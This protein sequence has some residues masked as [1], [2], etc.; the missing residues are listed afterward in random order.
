MKVDER[1]EAPP[2]SDVSR[3]GPGGPRRGA[4]LGRVAGFVALCVACVGVSVGYLV[5]AGGHDDRPALESQQETPGVVETDTVAVSAV[6]SAP[7]VV[8]RTLAAGEAGQLAATPLAEPGGPRALA[9]FDCLRIYVTAVNGLCLNDNGD[10]FTPYNIVFLGPDLAPRHTESLAGLI[11]R[12]RVSPDGRYGAASVFVTGHSYAPGSFSTQTTLYDMDTG[13]LLA[14]L[15]HFEVFKDGE[16]IE[17]PDFNFWGVTF[18]NQ[19]G[20]FY[21]TL[22]TAGH[23]YLVRGDVESERVD[24]LR[25]GIECPSLSPDNTKIAFKQRVDSGIG[26]IE[27]R[28]AVLD[29]ASLED[30]RLAEARNI[31]DQIEWLDNDTVLYSVDTG[32]GAPDTWATPADGTGEPRLFLTDAD[33][34]TVIRG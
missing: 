21:A 19:P 17:S 11:S 34:P 14:D 20:R 8:F 7:H 28:P 29:V 18:A 31:D 30:H 12:A 9:D 22:G 23:T 24:V 15:E 4:G 1:L 33:T 5:H 25:D 3:R 2:A 32:V 10:L 13:E 6:R 27:W 16:R 26:P